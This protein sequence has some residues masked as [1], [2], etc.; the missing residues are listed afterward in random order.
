MTDH[1]KDEIFAALSTALG[2]IM[3]IEE[4]VAQDAHFVTTLGLDSLDALELV[5]R[6]EELLNV[7]INEDALSDVQ[8]VGDFVDNVYN[9]IHEQ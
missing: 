2:E 7:S 9:Q 1:T 5:V 4:T 6:V 3:G 8:T